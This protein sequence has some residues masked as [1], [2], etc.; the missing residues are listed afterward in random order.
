MT[1][2]PYRRSLL[3]LSAASIILLAILLPGLSLL[4]QALVASSFVMFIWSFAS[5]QRVLG[6]APT[7]RFAAIATA[8]GWF[9]EQMGSSHGWFFGSYD[10]TDVLGPTIGDVPMVIPMMWFALCYAGYTIANLIAWQVPSDGVTSVK[11]TLALSFLAA[12]VVTNYDLGVDPY[13]VYELKAWIMEKKDGWWFGETLQGFVGWMLV[14]FTIVLLFRLSLR[15]WSPRPTVDARL[16]DVLVPL[17]IYGGLMVFEATQGVPVE[18]RTIALFA[19]GTPLFCAACGLQRW[20]A[21]LAARAGAA[22][23]SGQ[24]DAV[25]PE[26]K[27]AA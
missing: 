26:H 27:E 12:L 15:K 7:V 22:S 9:A 3:I 8:V 13:M 25:A 11:R 24:S 16:R 21:D 23:A 20:R 2:T 5:A 1:S 6:I 10:Y 4:T 17:A 14:S 19:M 18:T